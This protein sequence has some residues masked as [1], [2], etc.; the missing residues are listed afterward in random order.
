MK[1]YKV[2]DSADVA[3]AL[4]NPHCVTKIPR[5]SLAGDQ[6][7]LSF[8]VYLEREECTGYYRCSC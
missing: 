8:L 3:D 6:A 7:I 4:S 2:F 1:H 5:Y